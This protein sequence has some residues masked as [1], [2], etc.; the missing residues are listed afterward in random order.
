MEA[1]PHI[2]TLAMKPS[3]PKQDILHR[4]P[5]LSHDEG[6]LL[7]STRRIAVLSWLVLMLV[8][9]TCGHGEA[10]SHP[11]VKAVGNT[12]PALLVSDIHLDPF[13]DPARVKQ[14]VH[15]EPG[16]WAAILKS[17]SSAADEQAFAA[18]QQKCHARGVDTPY[19]LLRSSLQAMRTH[20]PGAR[21]ITVSGD[22]IA[23]SFSC[24]YAA[25]L[26]GAAA[27][28]YE[29]FVVKTIDFVVQELRTTFPGV[30]VYV[31]LGNNDS[32]CDDY[33]LDA[34][35]NFLARIGKVV[36][37]ALPASEQ[38]GAEKQFAA[39]GYYSVTMAAPMQATR[40][41]VINDL[42]MAPR[43]NTCAGKSDPAPAAA[44]IKWLRDELEQARRLGQTAWVMGHI[45]PGV[46]PYSTVL[47]FRD[48]C[49][50]GSPDMFLSSDRLA[51][52]LIE[53][54][55]VIRLGIFAHTHMD[56]I[57]LLS[58]AGAH[59]SP[60]HSV[61]LKLVPSISP[62]NGNN[63]AFTVAR[64]NPASGALQDYE[65]I[66]ASNKTGIAATWAIEYDYGQTYHEPEFSPAAVNDL[67][68]EFNQDRRA[69]T[70][71]SEDY[72]RHYF[73]G[74]ELSPELKPF[75]PQYVCSL[76]NYTA[77]GFAACVCS[78]GK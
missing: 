72:I 58:P 44:Q 61:A 77:K 24:R 20:Q 63:P 53:Y 49:G 70:Q 67:T 59:G 11:A 36:V 46:D 7:K 14:L 56:E 34:G 9:S 25:L 3:M 62:V 50:S 78:P 47:K 39:G 12:I 57:H 75:W 38:A 65:V 18:L 33:R 55:G 31:A 26:P 2:K 64:V 41:I 60:E 69:S 54:A 15:A 68:A 48:V 8:V 66:A 40:L 10:Q 4:L 51:E 76:G 74:G 28:D 5:V 29:T 6:E 16:Q 30:P 22:L 32:G 17:P 23:H 1:L 73:A 42:F 27:G 45:P 71:V 35:S 37:D 21:F 43:Y 52:A 13:H 19:P